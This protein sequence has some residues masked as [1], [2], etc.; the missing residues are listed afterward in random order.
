MTVI[1][2][3]MLL[4]LLATASAA[5][6]AAAAAGAAISCR[7]EAGIPVD[8]WQALKFN[9]GTQY[10]YADTNQ[11]TPK[12]STYNMND[13]SVG[14]LTHTTKQLWD[15]STYI[16]YNDEPPTAW[17]VPPFTRPFKRSVTKNTAAVPVV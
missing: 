2:T 4:L 11:P 13:T 17:N 5:S 14:A 9:K 1:T 10:L 7:D 15:V 3:M 6:A 8:S 16:A 12:L